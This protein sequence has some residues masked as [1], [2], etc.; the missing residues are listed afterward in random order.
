ML[1]PRI[2]LIVKC[3]KYSQVRQTDNVSDVSIN[4]HGVVRRWN[5]CMLNHCLSW[6]K[7]VNTHL[8]HPRQWFNIH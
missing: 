1:T 4:Q 8:Y 5:K 7:F 2:R 6:L 3:V